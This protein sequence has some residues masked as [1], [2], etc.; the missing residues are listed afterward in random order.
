MRRRTG[1]LNL[2]SGLLF[3]LTALIA[4]VTALLVARVIPPPAPFAPFT[5]TLPAVLA[6]PTTTPTSRPS[7]TPFPS[8][9]PT[10]TVTFTPSFT[11]SPTNQP[12]TEV[13]TSLPSASATL[14]PLFIAP[15]DASPSPTPPLPT[16]TPLILPAVPTFTPLPAEPLTPSPT[17]PP[18]TATPEFP[19]SPNGPVFSAYDGAEGCAFQGIGGLVLGLRQERLSALTGVRIVIVGDDTFAFSAVIEA[20]SRY[21]WL[22]QIGTRQNKG[23]YQVSLQTADG[24]VLAP[25]IT[26]AF[27]GACDGNFALVN[28]SQNRPF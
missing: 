6:L 7:R 25:I 15:T 16:P 10:A 21:S 2:L 26:V 12:R 28:F 8:P 23:S 11:P 14:P 19:F 5:A 3:G 1:C 24:A 9:T 17:V 13:P 18:P 4:V 22:A 27:S 20:E